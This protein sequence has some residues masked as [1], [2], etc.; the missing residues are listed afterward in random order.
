MFIQV[1]KIFRLAVTND[2]GDQAQDTMTV[3]V[4]NVVVLASKVYFAASSDFSNHTLWVSDGTKLVL[5]RLQ[6]LKLIIIKLLIIKRLVIS[7]ILKVMMVSME[8]NYGVLTVL[9]REQRCYPVQM[10]LPM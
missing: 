1:L 8:E 4:N 9:F 5:R 10:I 7:F 2:H 3:T 6:L